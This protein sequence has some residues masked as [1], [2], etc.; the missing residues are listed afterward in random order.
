M[1]VPKPLTENEIAEIRARFSRG[2][3]IRSLRDDYQIGHKRIHD[4]TQDIE[5]HIICKGCGKEFVVAPHE[6][7]RRFCSKKCAQTHFNNNARQI[8][9]GKKPKGKT[10]KCKSTLEDTVKAANAAG[11][12]YGQYVLMRDYLHKEV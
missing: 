3:S 12:S 7:R 4:L 5:R 9:A 10:V 2:D 1:Y 8:H 11:M 6:Y